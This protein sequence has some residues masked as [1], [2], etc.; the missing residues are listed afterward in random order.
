MHYNKSMTI[1]FAKKDH[2][3]GILIAK[4]DSLSPLTGLRLGYSVTRKS[5]GKLLK[6]IDDA[7]WV[8]EIFTKLQ[9]GD[10]ISVVQH[11][12]RRENYST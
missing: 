3:C 10:V 7:N 11:T 6:S 4:L 5:D 8:E 1:I 9:D 12:E 2:A